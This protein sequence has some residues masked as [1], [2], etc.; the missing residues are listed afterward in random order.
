MTAGTGLCV[1]IVSSALAAHIVQ[2]TLPGRHD[3][4]FARCIQKGGYHWP[5]GFPLMFM[6]YAQQ[7][8]LG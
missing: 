8:Q 5:G 1:L 3:L 7:S 6:F 4:L 2:S